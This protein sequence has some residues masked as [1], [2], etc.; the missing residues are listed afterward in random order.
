MYINT[1]ECNFDKINI[2]TA[3]ESSSIRRPSQIGW[4]AVLTPVASTISFVERSLFV[5]LWSLQAFRDSLEYS[6]VL[7]AA[8]CSLWVTVNA[9]F[10]EGVGVVL[11][12]C[13]QL[14]SRS[15]KMFCQKLCHSLYSQDAAVV[16]DIRPL[17]LI[18]AKFF[19]HSLR[20]QRTADAQLQRF[21][22]AAWQ[23]YFK[24][25]LR[26]IGP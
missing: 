19:S 10:I 2:I 6:H 5:S 16:I 18:F 23:N 1:V 24:K 14:S 4:R 22:N 15:V 11:V 12:W 13:Q 3:V 7:A 9:L 21:S 17:L 25:Y 8:V 26:K 20:F